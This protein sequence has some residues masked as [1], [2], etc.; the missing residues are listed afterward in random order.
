MKR[1]VMSMILASA[2]AAHA[3]AADKKAPAKVWAKEPTSFLGVD[4]QGDVKKSVPECTDPYGYKDKTLCY[5]ELASSYKFNGLPSLGL[6]YA[7]ELWATTTDGSLQG[8]DLSANSKDYAKLKDLLVT[9]YG[10]PTTNA[11]G[12]VKTKAGAEFDNE[13]LLWSGRKVTILLQ[14]Y[15]R[16]INTSS[17]FVSNNEQT[18][19][20]AAKRESEKASAAS[21][22]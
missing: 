15:S 1:L 8:I 5:V 10:P 22:L 9:K 2:F 21:K 11:A 20:A 17:A 6:S 18:D 19:R 13:T 4:L 12:K 14:K 7:Y 3:G 16:D